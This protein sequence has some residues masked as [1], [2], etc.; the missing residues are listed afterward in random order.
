[1]RVFY[2][3]PD[4]LSKVPAMFSRNNALPLRVV[5][6][7]EAKLEI[8]PNPGGT[9]QTAGVRFTWYYVYDVEEL[10]GQTH[11]LLGSMGALF[12][13]PYVVGTNVSSSSEVRLLGWADAKSLKE[14]CSN[15]VLEYNTERKAVDERRG[16][17]TG[18]AKPARIFDGPGSTTEVAKEPVEEFWKHLGEPGSPGATGTFEAGLAY[19]DPLGLDPTV[20]RLHVLEKLPRSDGDWFHVATLGST[21]GEIS[22]SE[23][24]RGMQKL[25]ELNETLRMVDIAFVVDATGSMGS[26][27]GPDGTPLGTVQQRENEML[28]K[29]THRNVFTIPDLHFDIFDSLSGKRWE[30]Q[31][32]EG[33][34]RERIGIFDERGL[35]VAWTAWRFN[36]VWRKYEACS[37]T[38]TGRRLIVQNQMLKPWTLA[39][40]SGDQPVGRMER[41]FSGLGGLLSGGN[42]M[43]LAIEPDA[44]DAPLMWALIAAALLNDLANE[45]N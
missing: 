27:L 14:W 15:T 16:V 41:G 4:I 35:M 7:P 12:D 3:E 5:T 40:L 2:L 1:M 9:P 10:N 37:C 13:V 39:V 21:S 32:E 45:E 30:F 38:G 43:R 36:L 26:I 17:T 31:R 22:Q 44:V 8:A 6:K 18:T 34:A 23:I 20:P 33:L 25:R 11:Y 19:T 24:A 28:Q 29:M 42:Q